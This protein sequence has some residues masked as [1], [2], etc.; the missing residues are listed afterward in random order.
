MENTEQYRPMLWRK[1]SDMNTV[2]TIKQCSIFRSLFPQGC[3]F[4]FKSFSAK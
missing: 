1:A 2:D 4:S 3:N